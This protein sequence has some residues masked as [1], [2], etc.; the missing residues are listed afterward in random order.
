MGEV[1]FSELKQLYGA[2]AKQALSNF[3]FGKDVTL[4]TQV[5]D[6]YGRTVARVRIRNTDVNAEMVRSGADRA[7]LNYKKI[8]CYWIV[9][10]SLES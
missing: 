8:K 7:Y 4:F 3:I 2:R 5:R 10:W 1:D 6:R 9:S